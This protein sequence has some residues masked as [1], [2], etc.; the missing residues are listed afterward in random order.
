M[1]P[2]AVDKDRGVK[3]LLVQ[4]QARMGPGT[5]ELSARRPD[6]VEAVTLCSPAEPGLAAFIFTYGQAEGR[7][8]VHL[9]YPF[10][11]PT[12]PASMED[13]TAARLLD[14][15]AMHFEVLP[16]AEEMALREGNGM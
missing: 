10:P 15:L 12:V 13:L 16:L 8:G 6:V 5:F 1:N 4:L 14:L 9:A 3:R 11:D 2:W 7:Y